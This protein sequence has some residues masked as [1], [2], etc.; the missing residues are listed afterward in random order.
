[1]DI[2]YRILIVDD[3][4]HVLNALSRLLRNPKYEVIASTKPV[5]A[6]KTVEDVKV[7][8]IISDMRMPEMDGAEFLRQSKELKPLVPRILLTGHADMEETVRAINDGEIFAF[9]SKPWDNDELSAQ[10]TEALAKRDKE[11]MK[12][13][14]LHKLKQL[15]ENIE[16][17]IHEVEHQLELVSHEKLEGAQALSDAY[18]LMEESFLNLLDMKQ[19]GQRALAYQLEEIVSKLA[20]TFSMA[21]PDRKLL[22]QAARL[23]GIGKIGVPDSIL[24]LSYEQMSEEQREV[25]RNYPANGA[26]TLIAI[27][28]F[29]ACA[30][31]LFKQKEKPDGSG[32]PNGL[33][34]HDLTRVN[35]VFNT[36]LDYA[37]HRYTPRHTPLSHDQAI[38]KMKDSPHAYDYDVLKALSHIALQRSLLS[39]E[40]ETALVPV[41]ALEPGMIVNED[42]MGDSSIPLVRAGAEVSIS[43]INKLV[44]LEKKK[45]RE[46]RMIS[47]V[48]TAH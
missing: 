2:K 44:G 9:I 42:V 14:A 41:H 34:K 37:E 7:D 12:N 39:S 43:L 25:Y 19:P 4:Q 23:H 45:G 10:V 6:L 13:R 27:D 1:M 46:S 47:V 38:R 40:A 21:I 33:K 35:L 15:N 31:L 22:Y 32:F 36:A 16:H 8:L 17:S 18:S 3:E 20:E 28:S 26:V 11:R 24:A 48:I 30:D 5:T 29:S